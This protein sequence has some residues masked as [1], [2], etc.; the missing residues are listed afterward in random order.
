MMTTTESTTEQR[1]RDPDDWGRE[2]WRQPTIEADDTLIFSEPGR[3]LRGGDF[4]GVDCRS[5]SFA[6]VKPKFGEFTLCVKHGGGEERVSIGHSKRIILALTQM[7]SDALYW[8]LHTMLDIFHRAE[9]ETRDRTAS[10]YRRAFV[11]GRLKKRKQPGR[12]SYKVWID[13]A[14]A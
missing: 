14:A 6:V 11:S 13:P 10:E 2:P 3:V 7:D 8:T 4:G 5:H 1:A 12:E 9:S